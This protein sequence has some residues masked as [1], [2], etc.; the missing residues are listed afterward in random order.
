MS[1]FNSLK[2]WKLRL[3]LRIK[4]IILFWS[5]YFSIYSILRYLDSS[6]TFTQSLLLMRT[7]KAILFRLITMKL[8]S[9]KPSI[10]E[11]SLE[12][13]R[14]VDYTSSYSQGLK[15]LNQPLLQLRIVCIQSLYTHS[16]LL[17]VEK[18]TW[19]LENLWILLLTMSKEIGLVIS[20]E[21]LATLLEPVS[22][23]I[24]ELGWF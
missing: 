22:L 12:I 7:R 18:S 1:F 24:K 2:S 8:A 19:E 6:Y 11:D 16:S 5:I 9:G 10:A 20:V 15:T 23:S 17:L 14:K 3:A 21:R 4:S 13:I